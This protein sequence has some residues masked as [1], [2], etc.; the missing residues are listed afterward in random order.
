MVLVQLF[1][2]PSGPEVLGYV[3]VTHFAMIIIITLCRPWPGSDEI[4][5]TLSFVAQQ[6]L[7]TFRC[8]SHKADRETD[9]VMASSR[10]PLASNTR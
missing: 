9:V 7:P 6:R 3:S 8:D 10:L 2:N 5:Q 1:N 4:V